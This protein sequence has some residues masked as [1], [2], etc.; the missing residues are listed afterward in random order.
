[1]AE[2][3]PGLAAQ[4]HPELNGNITPSHIT[5]AGNSRKYWWLCR[6]DHSWEE[7][8]NNRA[9]GRGCPYCSGRSA[10]S[11]VN[12]LDATHPTI[13][14]EWDFTAN[15]G[16]SP[17]TVRPGSGLKVGWICGLGHRYKATV[18]ARS[19]RGQGCPVCANLRVLQGYKR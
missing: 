3:H 17:S 1:M 8:P 9:K 6:Q 16:T 7:S 13:A 18:D 12:S 14:S 4:W 11:G 19:G 2:T 10:I 15:T 5:G